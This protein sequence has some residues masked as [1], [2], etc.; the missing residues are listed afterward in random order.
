MA[1]DF[2]FPQ[3]QWTNYF[4]IALLLAGTKTRVLV[5]SVP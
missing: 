3:F 5:F 4:R 2:I 1:N